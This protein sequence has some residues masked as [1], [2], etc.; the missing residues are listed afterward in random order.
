MKN[1]TDNYKPLYNISGK[2]LI[3]TD[4]HFGL[5]GN[6]KK[7]LEIMISVFDHVLSIIDD[8]NVKNVICMGDVFHSRTMLDIYTLNVAYD[9][10]EKISKKCHCYFIIGNHDI[11]LK[12][13]N[14]IN[15]IK[16]LSDFVTC[17]D[18][19]S[20]VILNGKNALFVPW[21][22]TLPEN[23]VPKFDYMFGHFHVHENYYLSKYQSENYVREHF[24]E[25]DEEESIE[26][27]LTDA[28]IDSALRNSSIQSVWNP[29][30]GETNVKPENRPKNG[31]ELSIDDFVPFCKSSGILFSGHIHL[32]RIF[33]IKG[34][35][36]ILAGSA[37][38][39]T[40]ADVNEKRFIYLLDEK[41]NITSVCMTDFDD[42]PKI[43]QLRYS[44]IIKT[45]IDNFDFSILRNNIVQRVYDIEISSLDE[46]KIQ[47]KIQQSHVYEELIPRYDKDTVSLLNLDKSGDLEN[48][49]ENNDESL[50][51]KSDKITENQF[52]FLEKIVK[53]LVLNNDSKNISGN[54]IN[55]STLLSVLKKYYDNCDS[56]DS[57]R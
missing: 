38:P 27:E 17:I 24:L 10:I 55:T 43:M 37:Y 46:F 16:V 41:N 1:Q 23:T 14:E 2:T 22:G 52:S 5:K 57:T 47:E 33:K 51:H 11:Y 30:D 36:V 6:S 31:L 28:D 32:N 13:T 56:D 15:A 42:I 34:R 53:K 9:L 29:E 48:T 18:K 7:R 4:L 8:Q 35:T 40:I 21:L 50:L 20:P 45:G 25:K 49:E 19:T 26:N 3:L 39:Q 12:S 54:N 44:D